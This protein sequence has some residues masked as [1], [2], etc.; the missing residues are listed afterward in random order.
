MLALVGPFLVH[1]A[2]GVNFPALVIG[3]G[4]EGFALFATAKI[5]VA[6]RA[7]VAPDDLAADIQ[8]AMTKGAIHQI[9]LS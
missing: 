2:L 9:M 8:H 3:F 6:V 4:V 1:D 5:P 7:R